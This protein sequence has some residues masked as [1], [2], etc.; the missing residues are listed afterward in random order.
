MKSK[1][2][3]YPL[4]TGDI[5]SMRTQGGG[6]YGSPSERDT[7]AIEKDVREGKLTRERARADYGWGK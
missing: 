5:F 4:R 7:A 3:G 2:F 6:G 1:N